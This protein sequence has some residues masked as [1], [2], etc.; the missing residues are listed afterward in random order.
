MGC[1]NSSGTMNARS[2]KEDGINHLPRRESLRLVNRKAGILS[3]CFSTDCQR[4]ESADD[5]NPVEIDVSHFWYKTKGGRTLG[6]G[7][8][9][10]VRRVVKQTGS[11]KGTEYAM[12]SMSK[13]AI[14]KRSSGPLSV[15]TELRA[16]IMLQDCQYISNIRYAFQDSKYIY[17]VLDL[18]K[19]GDMR[20]NMR[21]AT[22]S[23]FTESAAKFFICQILLAVSYCHK[24]S[25]LHRG[26][27]YLKEKFS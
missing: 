18:A 20:Y 13:A 4:E 25:I 14:L 1:A 26:L 2:A 10:I 7:G 11:D 22:H 5:A 3:I 15:M 12:K 9:G 17:I 16:L 23:R 24:F 8:F 19:G 6:L 21:L 27:V